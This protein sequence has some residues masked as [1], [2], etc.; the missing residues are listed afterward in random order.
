VI[1]QP[2][3][4]Q[5]ARLGIKV[6]DFVHESTLPP[7][8]TVYRQPR[9]IQPSVPRQ[10]H[11]EDTEPLDDIQQS[12]SDSRS[13]IARTI[14][15]PVLENE[16]GPSI[17]REMGGFFEINGSTD[18]IVNSQPFRLHPESP[19]YSQVIQPL[20]ASQEMGTFVPTP[21]VTPNGSLQWKELPTSTKRNT[22][23][24]MM[25][26]RLTSHLS[27][28][29]S[30]LTPLPPSPP[31]RQGSNGLSNR[32]PSMASLQKPYPKRRKISID[33]TNSRPGLKRYYLRKRPLSTKYVSP[34][35]RFHPSAVVLLR[36]FPY[37]V[38]QVGPFAE[39]MVLK[40]IRQAPDPSTRTVAPANE[41]CVD[42]I[43]MAK[44]NIFLYKV[45]F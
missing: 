23:P 18:R 10:L 41:V 8:R 4:A 14:T 45:S 43:T 15:E 21:T 28:F 2:T 30:P 5:L 34:S 33:N 16:A 29:S 1:N 6:R 12:Q 40:A 39:R 24:P 17:A 32:S 35:K 36:P 9:Q 11:R 27:G 44:C 38:C 22:P 19:E 7:V 13:G 25:L 42:S 20:I 3:A 31:S 37:C 26:S